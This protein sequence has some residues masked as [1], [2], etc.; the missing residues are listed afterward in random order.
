VTCLL[1]LAVAACAL[2]ACADSGPVC[3][4]DRG[5]VA[6]V[7]DGD[8]VELA[9]GEK[10]R[11]LLVDTPE[12]VNG[13]DDCFGHEAAELDRSLVLGRE[14]TLRYDDAA[15]GDAAACHDRYGRLLAYVSVDGREV[16]T[17][18]VER[19]YA[20]VLYLPPAGTSRHEAFERLEAEARAQRRGLW[21][22][23]EVAPCE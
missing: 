6:R 13:A 17:L 18:L 1:A 5:V 9:S 22:A 16:N 10:V 20:C 12:S 21:A 2:A 19:G 11:Y 15:A 23:C 14:V 7:V 8:T 3:G 4:P